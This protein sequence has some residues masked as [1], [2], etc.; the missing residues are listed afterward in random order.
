[1]CRRK[2][3]L[4]AG[5]VLLLIGSGARAAA[6]DAVAAAQPAQQ[7]S[8]G[9]TSVSTITSQEGPLRQLVTL[10]LVD[11][12]L[13]KA[14]EAIARQ[15]G[16]TLAYAADIL[17]AGTTVTLQADSA[18][19]AD[20]LAQILD[21]TG[22]EHTPTPSGHVVLARRPTSSRSRGNGEGNG[23]E[24]HQAVLTGR[25][26]DAETGRPLRGANIRLDGTRHRTAT[27]PEGRY[28]LEGLQPGTYTVIAST[29]GYGEKR[30]LLTITTEATVPLDFVLSVSAV[31]LDEVV[32][33]GTMVPT[34][35]RAVPSPVS[36]IT[37]E[38]IERKG[39]VRFEEVLRSLPGVGLAA[40]HGREHLAFLSIRGANTLQP[41]GNS[42]I[43]TYIDGV[44]VANPVYALNQID[45]ATIERVELI[46]GPQA[47]TLHGSGALAG[48]LQVFT[49]KGQ[50]GIQPHTVQAT[51]TAG[52]LQSQYKDE[53][54]YI[55]NH[56]IG[57][58]GGD[59]NLSYS[60]GASYSTTGEWVEDELIDEL[61]W[62]IRNSGNKEIGL[63]AG[64]R[65][66]GGPL[67]AEVTG[68]SQRTSRYSPLNKALVD[69][70]RS[71]RWNLPSYT[72]PSG[73]ENDL[74]F[75]TYGVTVSYTSGGQWHHKLAV[76]HD[77]THA[78]F[79]RPIARR[80]VPADTLLLY[81]SLDWRRRS[82][83]YSTAAEP[84]LGA[85]LSSM[86]QAGVDGST[87]SQRTVLTQDATQLTGGLGNQTANLTRGQ[88]RDHGFFGQVQLGWRSRMFLTAGL[89]ADNNSGFGDDYGYAWSPRVGLAHA[90]DV[91]GVTLKSRLSFGT[92]IRPPEPHQK[93]GQTL[94]TF[95][96]LANEELGPEA[97]TGYDFGVE[98][99]AW[100][101]VSA[102]ITRYSQTAKDLIGVVSMSDPSDLP[103]I[104]QFQNIGRIGNSGWE[105]EATIR[106][107]PVVLSGHYSLMESRVEQLSPTYT[108]TDFSIG[109]R[110]LYVPNNT[111]GVSA[112]FEKSRASVS[113]AMSHRGS[114]QGYRYLPY[115]EALF[116]TDPNRPAYTGSLRDY[117]DD[118]TAI[119]RYHANGSYRIAD[120][121]TALV[122][123]DNLLN[124]SKP[125][126][127][128]I[129]LVR[130]RQLL[131]GLRVRS[132][133]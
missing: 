39:V 131:I 70:A 30:Q 129:D 66:A 57:V 20:V 90:F 9:Q 91:R 128:D 105:I 54:T 41:I 87:F 40:D 63:S 95:T 113:I 124:D 68:R 77:E 21:G 81:Q 50:L 83:A 115:Y 35:L 132:R 51:L 118:Y 114:W 33:T 112:T 45:P 88:L 47:S 82:L 62:S 56:N 11:A 13:G 16:L 94:A 116:G 7:Q 98:L 24:A 106:L 67:S 96:T 122:I 29:I 117:V 22:I 38:D 64:L 76:G 69:P 103:Q 71:D 12:P 84:A 32:V 5:S 111:G 34:Q 46:R 18:A 4:S 65:Y 31:P 6:D 104:Q 85:D 60:A 74:E 119:Q 59:Q 130:G 58:T 55:Q 93:L 110:P 86:I 3:L 37:A 26:T 28:R 52:G 121:F 133:R 78:E 125:D 123:V 72:K 107:P 10:D 23:E 92:A 1:M 27:N 15:A 61:G 2:I 44:E 102:S 108:G 14:L 17:P 73:T 120:T 109:Q 48:V 99:H 79:R 80:T 53:L 127:W 43:K 101:H 42:A 8:R 100:P 25:V 89:R 19:A 36:V 126:Q 49:K 97:Q 75:E